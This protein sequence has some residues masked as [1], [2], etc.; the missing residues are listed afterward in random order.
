MITFFKNR[1]TYR[2]KLKDQSWG[3]FYEQNEVLFGV[4]F[5]IGGFLFDIF[6]L[7]D[8]DD[9]FSLAQQGIYLILIGFFLDLETREDLKSWQVPERWKK[10]WVLREMGLHF[11]LGSLLSLYSL[12]FFKS[13]S[14]ATSFVFML[15]IAALL[16]ANEFPQLQNRGPLVRWAIWSLCLLCFFQIL[17]PIGLGW[18]GLVPFLL[19]WILALAVIFALIY[20]FFGRQLSEHRLQIRRLFGPSL[21]VLVLFFVMY[22]LKLIPPVPLVLADIGI[23]HKVEKFGSNYVFTEQ[24]PWWK[25]WQ[26]GDQD[27]Q[28]RPGDHIY[29]YV[30]VS[31]PAS[32]ADEVRIRWMF[33]D[34]RL[35]WVTSDIIPMRIVGGR[36][37]GYRGFAYKTRYEEGN[38]RVQVE[39][40][41][42]REIG[43]LSF[44]VSKV[45][46][47]AEEAT[48]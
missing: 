39:T 7:S 13:A 19:A 1:L 23:Y 8:I 34:S 32:I 14:L 40:T 37:E 2:P 17:V 41:D 25:F 26:R 42:E 45:N 28:A 30:A 21:T 24:R 15:V 47:S 38:W 48:P 20:R 4:L 44:Q 6:T 16:V 11:F 9:T 33:K 22:F 3:G 18:V 35:G 31:S 43:R 46:P 5:F 29:V 12:F 27:F 36:G 10:I